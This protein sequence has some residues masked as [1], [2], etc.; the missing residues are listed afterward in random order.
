MNSVHQPAGVR[1]RLDYQWSDSAATATR[2]P[3]GIP[4]PTRPFRRKEIVMTESNR[5]EFISKMKD[6]LDQLDDEI[7]KLKGKSDK[8]EADAR[9]EYENRMHDLR[10]KRREAKRTLDDLRS[11]SEEKWQQ[12]KDEAEHAWKALGNS[13]NYFKSHFK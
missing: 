12:M 1:D 4:S 7:E 3:D 11:A 5:N 9:K 6:R 2:D 8:L 13:F 10:E